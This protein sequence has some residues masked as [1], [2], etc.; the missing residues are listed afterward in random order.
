MTPKAQ[1]I[2]EQKWANWTSS[3][4]NTAGP[5]AT[6]DGSRGGEASANRAPPRADRFRARPTRRPRTTPREPRSGRE[7]CTRFSRKVNKQRDARR[8]TP[9]SSGSRN[10]Q[11]RAPSHRTGSAAEKTQTHAA[12]PQARRRSP[13]TAED[14]KPCSCS[15]DNVAFPQERKRQLSTRPSDSTSNTASSDS[16]SYF[17]KT[18][19][20]HDRMSG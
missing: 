15:E 5:L 16:N 4:L 3:G 7:Y 9:P 13:H 12:S 6:E 19:N 10:R 14:R 8:H 1:A 17:Y 18:P 2:K 11:E 20:V